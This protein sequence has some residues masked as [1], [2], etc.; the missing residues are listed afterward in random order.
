LARQYNATRV[1]PRS[2]L[3]VCR[4]HALL[5]PPLSRQHINN[6]IAQGILVAVHAFQPS[7][8]R[9]TLAHAGLSQKGVHALHQDYFSHDEKHSHDR[10]FEI[11]IIRK[12][13][14]QDRIEEVAADWEGNVHLI[15][16]TAVISFV[17]L[18]RSR[19]SYWVVC[20]LKRGTHACVNWMYIDKKSNLEFSLLYTLVMFGKLGL[21]CCCRRVRGK[22]P[23]TTQH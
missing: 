10:T 5:S 13:R 21:L 20:R 17:L 2:A 9:S 3:W 7:R 6:H 8:H 1:H 14:E 22:A 4:L 11:F 18:S 23:K 15:L 19:I 12:I 16:V